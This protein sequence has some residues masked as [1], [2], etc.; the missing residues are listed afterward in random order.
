VCVTVVILACTMV[1]QSVED[2]LNPR[3]RV[4]HVSVRRFRMRPAGGKAGPE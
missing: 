2:S 1:G 3:L 4:G